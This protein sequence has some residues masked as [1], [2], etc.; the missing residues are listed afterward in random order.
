MQPFE[1]RADETRIR[2]LLDALFAAEAEVVVDAPHADPAVYGLS[3]ETR[4]ASLSLWRQDEREAAVRLDLGLATEQGQV[5]AYSQL[6]KG[7][8]IL[9]VS[10]G[11][12]ER[13]AFKAPEFRDRYRVRV[14]PDAAVEFRIRSGDRRLTAVRSE[15]AAWRLI[16]PVQARAD[17]ER[18][19]AFL[20]GLP[21]MAAVAFEE[22]APADAG[23]APLGEVEVYA[24]VPPTGAVERVA[25]LRILSR[26]PTDDR[27]RADTG[28]GVVFHLSGPAVRHLFGEEPFWEPLRF[29]DRAMLTLS[30]G[31]IKRIAVVRNAAVQTVERDEKGVWI[32]HDGRQVNRDA[33]ESLLGAVSALRAVRLEPALPDRMAAYGLEPPAVRVEL[34]LAGTGG[35]QKNLIFGGADGAGNRYVQ[36]QGEEPVFVVAPE[37]AILLTHDLLQ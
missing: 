18:I 13:L 24:A 28:T 33:V 10:T 29:R 22:A 31:A 17:L 34:G 25:R 7:G 23:T 27:Y 11:L 21:A 1:D 2:N 26:A 4:F 16:E 35:I 32:S 14:D 5:R 36:V 37:L 30:A 6:G 20:T 8:A 9:L 19:R 12:L 15:P 3:P